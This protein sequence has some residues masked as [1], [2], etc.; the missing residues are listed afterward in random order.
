MIRDSPCDE[1]S[2]C[3][4]EWRSKQTTS[5]PRLLS[6]HAVAAPITP[7]PMTATFMEVGGLLGPDARD[8]LSGFHRIPDLEQ[9]LL[10]DAG[11]GGGDLGVDLVGVRLHEGLAL[12]HVLAPLLAPRSDGDLLRSLQLGHH[13]LGDLDAHR[14]IV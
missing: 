3:G 11:D 6:L 12:G 1:P 7:P 9:E 10:D 4:G 2:G 5:M 13:D 14:P 8:R